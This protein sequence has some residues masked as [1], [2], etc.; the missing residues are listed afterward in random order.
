V[1]TAHPGASRTETIRRIGGPSK[2]G[3]KRSSATWPKI[4]STRRSSRPTV[5][6]HIQP[7]IDLHQNQF[8]PDQPTWPEAGGLQMRAK[9]RK[10][11]TRSVGGNVA[12]RLGRKSAR[13]VGAVGLLLQAK[14]NQNRLAPKSTQ[15]T[16]AN[17]Q[18][19]HWTS[20]AAP[21][22]P[23]AVPTGRPPGRRPGQPRPIAGSKQVDESAT[24]HGRHRPA[25][26]STG[27]AAAK[28]GLRHWTPPVAPWRLSTPLTGGCQAR[29][30]AQPRP[31]LHQTRR[32]PG[33]P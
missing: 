4:G 8:G 14:I 29:R 27:V 24:V 28:P 25:A 33:K 32:Q 19:R 23:R 17:P 2:C 5:P 15:A 22:R 12:H 7:K 21:Q 30:P 18:L 20:P 9:N 3:Q 1:S 10:K 6:H 31:G 11:S 16:T 26:T 13:P